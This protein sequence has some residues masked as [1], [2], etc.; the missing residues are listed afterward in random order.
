M[1][2]KIGIGSI[3]LLLF[4]IAVAWSINFVPFD[5]CLGESVL[6]L[7]HLPITNARTGTNYTIYYSLVFLIPAIMIANRHDKDLFAES[8]KGLSIVYIIVLFCI[9]VFSA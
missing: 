6:N 1:K 3:S 5:F 2:K 8:G 4:V 7:L 9:L